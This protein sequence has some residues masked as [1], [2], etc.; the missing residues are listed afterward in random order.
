[1]ME[2]IGSAPDATE[3]ARCGLTGGWRAPLCNSL[4]QEDVYE[5]CLR[6]SR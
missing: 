4:E 3:V 5:L 2:S 1:M 6:V